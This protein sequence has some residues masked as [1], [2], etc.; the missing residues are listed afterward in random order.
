MAFCGASG[1]RSG[2]ERAEDGGGVGESAQERYLFCVH[3]FQPVQQ[4]LVVESDGKGLLV[5]PVL[6]TSVKISYSS[7]LRSVMDIA[8]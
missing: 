4:I 7:R 8:S 6:L 3:G 1:G 2:E 5:R